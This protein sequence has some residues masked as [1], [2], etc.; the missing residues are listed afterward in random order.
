MNYW[1]YCYI[2]PISSWPFYIDVG[3]VLFARKL[4]ILKTNS[5]LSSEVSS[6]YCISVSCSALISAV[7]GIGLPWL[8]KRSVR[9]KKAR[10]ERNYTVFQKTSHLW[11]AI[12]FGNSVTEK[13]RN[14]TMFCFSISPI[15]YFYYLRKRKQKRQRTGAMCMQQSN[16][17]SALDFLSPVPCPQSSELNALITIFMKSYSSVSMSR[18]SKKIEEINSDWLSCGNALIQRTKMQFSCFLFCQV[19]QKHKLFEVAE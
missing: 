18:E 6:F 17:Y 16:C 8:L 10:L 1:L 15:Y 19:V 14:Q 4:I 3:Y 11:L 9:V 5:W 7:H 13:V 2:V 12:I